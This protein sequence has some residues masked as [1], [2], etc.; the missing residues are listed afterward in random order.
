LRELQ[1]R[2]E[3]AG[4]PFVSLRL[5]LGVAHPIYDFLE[6]D[7]PQEGRPWYIRVADI[8]GFLRH[9]APVLEQRLAGR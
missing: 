3:Q 8:P 4:Q 7:A 6:G 9:I 2:V 5:M 1:D